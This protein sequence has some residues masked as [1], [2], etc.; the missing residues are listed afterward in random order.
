MLTYHVK[1][2]KIAENVNSKIF[3]TK[4]NRLTVQSKCAVC[5]TK[6]SRFVKKKEAKWLLSS[7]GL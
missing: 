1:C 7:L 4:N 3:K 5:G 2:R 6:K